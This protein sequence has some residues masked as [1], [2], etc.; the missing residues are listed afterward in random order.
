MNQL[1]FRNRLITCK[2][3]EEILKKCDINIKIQKLELYKQAFTHKSYVKVD[4]TNISYNEI[5]LDDNIVDLQKNSNERFEFLGDSIIGHT[6]CQYLYQ[7]YYYRDEGFLTRLKTK[8]VDR[9]RLAIFA[10]FLNLG[11]FI[12]ISNH[13]ENIHGRNTNKILE[14]I[15]ESFICALDMEFG[16]DLSKKFLINILEKNVNFAELLYLDENYKDRLMQFF[17]HKGYEPPTYSRLIVLG[18]TN[19]RTFIMQAWLNIYKYNSKTNKK[20]FIEKKM[21]GT[22]IA[23]NKKEAE[24]VASRNALKKYH[25]LK[26]YELKEHEINGEYKENKPSPPALEL[27]ASADCCQTDGNSEKG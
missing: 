16:F 8:L 26:Y 5:L 27:R 22:G 20:E 9:K 19:K 15:F 25:N 12:L 23:T 18:P 14:D 3:V 21:V 2:D 1:N 11:D 4:K 13:M 24:Q 17:Q 7:R 10:R 6:I